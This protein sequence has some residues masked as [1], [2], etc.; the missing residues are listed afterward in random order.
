MGVSLA[1]SGAAG[2][3]VW[4]GAPLPAAGISEPIGRQRGMP[5][6]HTSAPSPS[7][8]E[9][10]AMISC[11]MVISTVS[12]PPRSTYQ[13]GLSFDAEGARWTGDDGRAGG[14]DGDDARAGGAVGGGGKFTGELATRVA[15]SSSSYTLVPVVALPDGERNA[16][17][18]SSE[19]N[20]C[21][22]SSSKA[23]A[24]SE[25]GAGA[26][27]GSERVSAS[28]RSSR[29]N[30]PHSQRST[31]CDRARA[32]L[33]TW[34][35]PQAPQATSCSPDIGR[36]GAY[37]SP[38]NR[39]IVLESPQNTSAPWIPSTYVSKAEKSPLF[40]IPS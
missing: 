19:E 10:R 34:R 11:S 40:N 23:S 26:G 32:A 31:R 7:F 33:I 18:S 5:A 21:V 2:D 38:L 9:R 25:S 22:S 15:A 16:A 37:L 14:D 24:S 1:R 4:R 8:P 30:C 17:R 12:V 39:Q 27:A 36:R 13:S 35:L 20:M 6:R 29:T 3:T 28:V